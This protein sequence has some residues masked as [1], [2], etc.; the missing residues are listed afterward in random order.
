MGDGMLCLNCGYESY[1]AWP[2]GTAARAVEVTR[3]M[4]PAIEKARNLPGGINTLIK[5]PNSEFDKW[6]TQG[7]D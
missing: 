4:W 2:I 6:V 3:E 7:E 5:R 1:D